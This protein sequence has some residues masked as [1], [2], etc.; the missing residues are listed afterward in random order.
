MKKQSV[1]LW[2]NGKVLKENIFWIRQ[3]YEVK[4]ITGKDVVKTD[5]SKGLFTLDEALKINYDK[6]MVTTSKYYFEIR[7]KLI[8]NYHINPDC[9]IYFLDEFN[10]ERRVS[11]GTKN[12][13]VTMYIARV[14]YLSSNHGFM[15]LLEGI[16]YVYDYCCK[17]RY[18]LLI[19]MKNYYTSY[20]GENYGKV[21]VWEEYFLQPSKYSLNE[22]Y[23]SKNVIIGNIDTA[24]KKTKY[25]S[26]KEVRKK[27]IDDCI[28]LGKLYGEKFIYS[29]VLR[30]RINSEL[31]RI[32]WNEKRILGV[33]ARGTDY[34]V[35]K[36][37]G[38]SIPCSCDQYI[39]YIKDYMLC[40]D[41]KY[42]YL[43]TEDLDVF[44]NFIKEFTEETLIFSD[45][46]RISLN[47]HKCLM[48]VQLY[49]K[50]DGYIRGMEYNLVIA[51]LAKCDALIANCLCGAVAGAL[52][53][54]MGNYSHIEIIDE[55]TYE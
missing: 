42:I 13:S 24:I 33:V 15:N 16:F 26:W 49:E 55:G 27:E 8:E 48:D 41:Y 25:M 34:I 19:D 4:G 39:K 45:Q 52:L 30:E 2:G 36:P 38:H 29:L 12:K 47:K 44:N 51:M 5:I 43:A 3:L 40:N 53:L 54:N 17:K 46:K 23:E 50:D 31:K 11:F 7:N 37:K 22:A 14:P 28:I 21:N 18:E 10:E 9:I 1:L 35:L 6:I 20:A 32:N